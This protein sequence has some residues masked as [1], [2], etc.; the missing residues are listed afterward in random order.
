V[1]VAIGNL[2]LGDL[3]KGMVRELSAAELADLSPH[4]AALAP[5]FGGLLARGVS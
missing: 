4:G 3:A 2:V 1:R 5:R